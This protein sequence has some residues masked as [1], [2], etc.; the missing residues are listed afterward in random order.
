MRIPQHFPREQDQIG[1]FLNDD[2]LVK[3]VLF[4]MLRMN[5]RVAESDSK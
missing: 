4:G 3:D 1:L 5:Q 2:F